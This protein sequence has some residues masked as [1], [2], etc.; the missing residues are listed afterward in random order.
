MLLLLTPIAIA[1]AGCDQRTTGPE[2]T[3]NSAEAA[4]SDPVRNTTTEAM[5][6]KPVDRA[7]AIARIAEGPKEEGDPDY[8]YEVASAIAEKGCPNPSAKGADAPQRHR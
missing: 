8:V 2:E 1:M 5:C 3:A 7:N 6:G 4:T